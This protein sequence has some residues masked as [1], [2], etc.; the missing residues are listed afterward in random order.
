MNPDHFLNFLLWLLAFSV[1]F[2]VVSVCY[3]LESCFDE[4]CVFFEV[5]CNLDCELVAFEVYELG[6]LQG[7]VYAFV[8]EDV[9]YVEDVFGFGVFHGCFPVSE[10]VEVNQ[11]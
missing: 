10:R 7:V 9:H 5:V 2:E 4:F 8:A 3:V 11:Q 1:Y 6:V